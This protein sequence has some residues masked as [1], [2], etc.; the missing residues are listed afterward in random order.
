MPNRRVRT[1]A[2]RSPVGG[3][4]DQRSRLKSVRSICSVRPTN[5]SKTSLARRS[6]DVDTC[7]GTSDSELKRAA[8]SAGLTRMKAPSNSESKLVV[9]S[10]DPDLRLFG[11]R[12]RRKRHAAASDQND[13][14]GAL[15]RLA[16]NALPVAIV[17]V[18][19]GALT[20][21]LWTSNWRVASS[22]KR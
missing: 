19:S 1:S 17:K 10:E 9:A 5:S 21:R 15:R 20:V 14:R 22:D 12:L 6:S 11:R 18:M 3:T 7:R 2:I 16:T 13:G 4:S 8:N